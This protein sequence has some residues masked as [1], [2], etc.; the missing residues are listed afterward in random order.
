MVTRIGP[1]QCNGPG[2]LHNSSR[3]YTG[4]CRVVMYEEGKK[5]SPEVLDGI[6]QEAL[7]NG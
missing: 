6:L 7:E 1:I 5:L 3:P 4:F 2:R